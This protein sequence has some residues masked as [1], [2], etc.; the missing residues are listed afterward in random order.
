MATL[1]L[2]AFCAARPAARSAAG[3][4][5]ELVA[6]VVVVPLPAVLELHALATSASAPATRG[7]AISERR[8]DEL[9]R[10]S[11]IFPP[12]R[13]DRRIIAFFDETG[14][15]RRISGNKTP[16]SPRSVAVSAHH[17]FLSGSEWFAQT[18]AGVVEAE[19]RVR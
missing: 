8:R 13:I 2:P 15:I 5:D 17:V 1:W 12:W 14:F 10:W 6:V 19:G 4:D 9:A 3:D 18:L 16:P 7:A 11:R